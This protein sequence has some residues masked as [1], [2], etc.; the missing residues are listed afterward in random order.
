MVYFKFKFTM[1]SLYEIPC[2]KLISSMLHEILGTLFFSIIML[3][4]R[5][6]LNILI[7]SADFKQTIFVYYS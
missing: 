2:I 4:I 6:R 3:F 5:P 1:H 7:F